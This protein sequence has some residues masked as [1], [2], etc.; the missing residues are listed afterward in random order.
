MGCP[1]ASILNFGRIFKKSLAHPHVAR[2]VM[3]KFHY[4]NEQTNFLSFCA[5]KKIE[6]D[7]WR[8]F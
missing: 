8:P 1:L 7:P 2:N 4:K 5:H 6:V 3:L